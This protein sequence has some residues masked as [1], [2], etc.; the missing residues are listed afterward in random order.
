MYFDWRVGLVALLFAIYLAFYNWRITRKRRIEWTRYLEDLSENIDWSTKNAVF[1]VPMP[2]VVVELDGSINWY[3]P[4]FG[5]LFEKESLLGENIRDCIPG[6]NPYSLLVDKKDDQGHMEIRLNDRQYRMFWTPIGVG[7]NR[8]DSK[9]LVFLYFQDI[10]EEAELKARYQDERP[11]SILVQVDN[12]D[13][14]MNNTDEAK[15]PVVQAQIEA[16]LNEW[17]ISLNAGWKKYER[18]KYVMFTQANSLKAL[19]ENRFQILDSVRAISAGNKIPVTLS[20]GVGADGKDPLEL[21]HFAQFALDLALGRG[22]D[23][24]VVKRGSR[25]F[26]YGGKSKEIEKRIKVKSRVIANTLRELMVQ[27]ERVFIMGHE[28]P[29]LDSLGSALGIYRCARHV[30]REAY[31]VLNRSNPSVH[32]LVSQLLD[33]EEYREAFVTA[34][35]ALDLMDRRQAVLVVVDVH[36]PSFM[37]AP[38]LLNEVEKIVVIDHHRRSAETIENPTLMY[39]EPYASSTSELV[40]EIIQYFDDKVE[41]EPIEADALLAGITVDTKNFIYKTGVRT[42]EAASYLRRAGANPVLVRQLF[43][44]DLETY[45]AR[46][47]VVKNAEIVLPGVALSYCSP[48]IKNGSL[49]AAQ[50]AD[51]LLTIKGIHTSFVLYP[52]G[53]D[54]IISGRSLGN[55]NVQMVLEK[56]GGGGHLTVAGAQLNGIDLGEARE[57]VISALKDYLEEGNK[58]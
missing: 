1:S 36:R 39:L 12:F 33:R 10:T 40:T 32:P 51:N 16:M 37:E 8:D 5:Q 52:D 7:N 54:V 34:D 21:S 20:I 41:L 56:L 47:E 14:V 35:E 38:R 49:I 4:R 27:S 3:N 42:F 6:L 31:I 50:A 25:L 46:A 13:E 48:G 58:K 30:G 24:A 53:G 15:R 18:D 43:Q 22:G 28:V 57:K 26:F 9:V 2:F 23:Q 19:E 45:V 55:V 44:D 11:V 29:D 17:A